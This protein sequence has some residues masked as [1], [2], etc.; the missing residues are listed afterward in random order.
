MANIS[1][2]EFR[3]ILIPLPSIGEQDG[4]LGPLR[5]ALNAS[6]QAATNASRLLL[7]ISSDFEDLVGPLP[8]P[9]GAAVAF[10][11]TTRNLRAAD[12][13]APEFFNPERAAMLQA[14]IDLPAMQ[15]K[16]LSTV[17]EFI[18]VRAE[19]ASGETVLALS[20]VES[21]TG[22]LLEDGD[23]VSS[24]KR[25]AKGDVLFGRLRPYLNKVAVATDDGVCS[26]EFYVLRPKPDINAEYLALAMRS[27]L[28]LGQVRHMVTG[29][30]HPRVAKEDA[31]TILVPVPERTV[32]DEL[33][34]RM[35]QRRAEAATLR[36]KAEE[37]VQRALAAFT[38]ALLE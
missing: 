3:S 13:L 15:P 2:T 7:D 23:D 24:G 5:Q 29:N 4:L 1:P 28:V 22:R 30:T 38:E 6:R 21:H 36:A 20:S 34:K 8:A 35:A 10:T 12:R 19:P 27:V 26:P 17:A 33:A 32:Q 37:E 11:T 9:A 25:Y 18:E 31:E 16:K 14:V